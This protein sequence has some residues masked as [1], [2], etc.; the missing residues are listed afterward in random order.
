[1]DIDILFSIKSSLLY[2]NI[3]RSFFLHFKIYKSELGTAQRVRPVFDTSII[4]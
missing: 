4:F 2:E 1:M 3:N